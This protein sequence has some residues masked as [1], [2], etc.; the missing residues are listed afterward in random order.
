KMQVLR[1]N[2]KGNVQ[3][4][5]DK[6]RTLCEQ[7]ASMGQAP[8]DKSF[9][10]III[11]SLPTSYDPQISAITALAKISSATF[12]SDALIEAIQDD[13]DRRAAKTKKSANDT[14]DAAYAA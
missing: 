14:E 5:F 3:E 7:L 1:C 12:T 8:T 10:V 11:G 6:R 9:T 4:H 2:K 13:Y